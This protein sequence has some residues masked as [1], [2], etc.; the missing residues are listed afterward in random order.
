MDKVSNILSYKKNINNNDSNDNNK[1]LNNVNNDNLDIAKYK[2]DRRKFTP[3]T[4]KTLL[5]EEICNELKDQHYAGILKLVNQLGCQKARHLL[6]TVKADIRE[7]E[8]TK[9]EIRNPGAYFVW[10]AKKDYL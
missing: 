9:Y 4:E 8:N 1:L 7:K 5:A 10:K 6:S 3:N 2:L